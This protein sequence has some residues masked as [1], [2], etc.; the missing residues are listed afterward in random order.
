MPV[1]DNC[2]DPATHRFLVVLRKKRRRFAGLEYL[3]TCFTCGFYYTL[4]PTRAAE[5]FSGYAQ[6]YG[7]LPRL[8]E[9]TTEEAFQLTK[10]AK[11]EIRHAIWF[12]ED[13]AVQALAAEWL[14]GRVGHG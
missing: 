7:N 12:A 8:L 3:T 6:A 5:G 4:G 1:C 9:E 2:G 13:R 10:R 14:D 11:I